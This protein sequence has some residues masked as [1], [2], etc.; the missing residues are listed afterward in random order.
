MEVADESLLNDVQ[1]EML[2]TLEAVFPNK[3]YVSSY[4]FKD[5]KI[6]TK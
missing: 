2:R 1:K 3:Q 5:P 4:C 6:Q